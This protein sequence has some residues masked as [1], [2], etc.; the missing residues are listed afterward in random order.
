MQK[1]GFCPVQR[2]A[3][4][5]SRLVS[6]TEIN[7][8]EFVRDVRNFAAPLGLRPAEWLDRILELLALYDGCIVDGRGRPVHLDTTIFL[9]TD[10]EIDN[11]T[12]AV[13]E[14]RMRNWFEETFATP[15]PESV[16]PHVRVEAK[17]RFRIVASILRARFPMQAAM[18]GVRAANDNFAPIP[19]TEQAASA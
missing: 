16:T 8:S 7:N 13:I 14:Y 2:C 3:G 9:P 17:E 18:W 1:C 19:P 4:R 5:A 10:D 12:A 11:G 15:V 6:D